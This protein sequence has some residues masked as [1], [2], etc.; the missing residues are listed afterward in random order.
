[1]RSGAL[2]AVMTSG[3]CAIG[4]RE[5]CQVGNQAALSGPAD[6]PRGRLLRAGKAISAQ[7][8]SSILGCM[9]LFCSLFCIFLYFAMDGMRIAVTTHPPLTR[10]PLPHKGGTSNADTFINRRYIRYLF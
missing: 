5:P 8:R 9:V 1:M 7:S 10:S 6:V 4:S 2:F 3:S